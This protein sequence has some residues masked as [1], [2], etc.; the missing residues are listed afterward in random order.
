MS[1][2]HNLDPQSLQICEVIWCNYFPKDQFHDEDRRLSAIELFFDFFGAGEGRQLISHVDPARESSVYFDISVVQSLLPFA[3]FVSTLRTKPNEVIGC[4]GCAISILKTK[5]FTSNFAE[6]FCLWPRFQNFQEPDTD[7]G[8]LRSGI[9]GQLVSISGYVVKVSSCRPLIEGGFFQCSRCHLN[10]WVTFE[11]GIYHPPEQCGAGKCGGKYLDFQRSNVVASD[12]QRIKLQELD[13]D[14]FAS[15]RKQHPQGGHGK[16]DLRGII[17]NSH[18]Y[19]LDAD[20]QGYNYMDENIPL[21]NHSHHHEVNHASRSAQNTTRTHGREA[22]YAARVPRTFD[23][24]VMI[25]FELIL[26]IVVQLCL[27]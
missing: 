23:V 25:F 21:A 19:P 26:V 12:Y 7:F 4:I 10:T 13:I 9:V 8:D 24:E 11:D 27:N 22:D 2:Q 5:E 1:Q 14:V 18:G 16:D 3:D 20:D 15:H 6:P 17:H